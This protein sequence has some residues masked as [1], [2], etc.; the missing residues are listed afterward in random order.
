MSAFVVTCGCA[1]DHISEQTA[2]GRR[3]KSFEGSCLRALSALRSGS[4]ENRL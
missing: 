3:V 1:W 4:F 2:K